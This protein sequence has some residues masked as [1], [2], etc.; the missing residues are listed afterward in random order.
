MANKLSIKQDG[1]LGLQRMQVYQPRSISVSPSSKLA[2]L[3]QLIETS[4]PRICI[5]RGEGIGDVLTTTPTIHAL[6]SLFNQV[7]ITYATNTSYLSGALVQTLAFNPDID[8]IIE[9][10]NMKDDDYDLIVNLH[11]PCI[12]YET[13][14]S[15]PPSR[16]DIFAKHAGIKLFQFVPRY[17]IQPAEVTAGQW[18][19]A[20]LPRAKKYIF[21]Q[22]HSSSP[23]RSFDHQVKIAL[24]RLYNEYNIRSIV[25]VHNND[26]KDDISWK[27]VPGS[28]LLENPDIR[29]I[30]SII[31]HVDLVL[32]PDSSIMHLAAALDKKT[33]AI[34]GPTW[35]HARINHYPKATYIWGGDYVQCKPCWYDECDIKHSC[36]RYITSTMIVDKCLEHLQNKSEQK[37]IVIKTEII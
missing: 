8:H 24:A 35:P 1:T 15:R 27:D 6:K 25:C 34:F 37:A 23:R 30:A 16:I 18:Y 29:R 28:I 7:E 13:K 17:F 19:M 3:Q 26:H 12:A 22:P 31:N 20:S 11:C 5:I 10:N 33:V 36:T 21:V 9:R 32:C 14:G 2:R 4:I